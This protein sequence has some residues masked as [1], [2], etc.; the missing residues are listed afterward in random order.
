MIDVGERIRQMVDLLCERLDPQRVILF[1]SRARGTDSKGSDI[2]LAVEGI[3]KLS[4][5][6]ERR[7]KEK[8]DEVS[9][10]LSVDLLFLDDLEDEDM[11]KVIRETG[12]VMYEKE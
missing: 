12:V 2:D 5:R 8:I 6:E 7:L 10:L 11:K 4:L 3:S 1:G 9:G